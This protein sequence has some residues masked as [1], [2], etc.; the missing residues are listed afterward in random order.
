MMAD[1]RATASVFPQLAGEPKG[2]FQRWSRDPGRWR[3]RVHLLVFA[4][5]VTAVVAVA[6][7]IDWPTGFNLRVKAGDISA[8]D[9]RAPHTVTYQSAILTQEA[10]DRAAA[11]VPR[12][13]DPLQTRIA[14]QQIARGEQVLDFIRQVRGDTFA[15]RDQKLA[16]L[17]SIADAPLDARAA[18]NVLDLTEERWQ[19]VAAD[20]SRVL[21]QAMRSEIREGGLPAA[22]RAVPSLIALGLNDQEAGIVSALVTG[23]LR[24]NTFLNQ[25]R[26]QAAQQEAAAKVQP[27]ERTIAASE[28][29]VRAGDRLDPLDVEALNA[30][31]LLSARRTWQHVVSALLLGIV[32][33]S[34]LVAFVTAHSRYVWRQTFRV[35]VLGS[36][37][38][39]F[40]ILAKMMVPMHTLMPYLYPMAAMAMLIGALIDLPVATVATLLVGLLVGIFTEGDMEIVVYA[41]AGAMVGAIALGR[42]ERLNAFA[43]SGIWIIAIL[44]AVLTLFRLPLPAGTDTRGLLELTTAA[45]V[46]GILSTSF[47]LVIFYLLGQVF[48][49]AT[50]LQLL[51]LSRPTHPLLRQLLLK[52]PGTYYHTL[53]V[54]NMVE[55]AATAIGADPLLA[56][57]GSYYHDIGKTVRPYFF[58]ENYV[59]STNPH[60]RLDPYTSAR[61]I[62]SHV[63][64]GIEL[65]HKYKLPE[66]LIDFIREHHG[67][68]RVEYFYHQACQEADNPEEVDES[69]FRYPGPKPHRRET[70]ILMLADGCEAT[71]RAMNPRTPEE[72]A[73]LVRSVVNR[74][75]M[76]GQLDDS[77]LTLRD[78]SEI[79]EAFLR[80]LR[81]IHHPRVRYPDAT[82]AKA[83]GQTASTPQPA[84][85]A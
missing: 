70:A 75:L 14:R 41:I 17:Q 64:D 11:G 73:E 37:F 28:I 16:W 25:E 81:G 54:S 40:V 58:V 35:A 78:L 32:I 57:V 72:T 21:D 50:S 53:I 20:T 52:A 56:R 39:G 19:A 55:E 3:A 4:I 69:A 77:R 36:L 42:A 67:S 1:E 61:I 24:E 68:T 29:I 74:R 60:E 6:D 38:C 76:L 49:L 34:L 22:Q 30:L 85:T 31:G 2:F 66:T 9:I 51:E 8:V 43:I 46:N 59:D 27:V 12:I 13:F 15:T 5:A 83:N 26:T 45:V 7:F 18:S 47:T 82:T 71:V 79:S 44:L 65:A 23:L 62:I 10:R 63:Q 48:G 84:A 33:S 80:V